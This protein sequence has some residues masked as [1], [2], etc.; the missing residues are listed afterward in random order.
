MYAIR[1]YYELSDEIK[2][3]RIERM[4]GI[5]SKINDVNKKVFEQKLKSYYN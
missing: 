1:S 2:Y 3:Q 5:I 4:N